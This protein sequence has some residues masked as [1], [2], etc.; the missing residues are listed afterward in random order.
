[1][2]SVLDDWGNPRVVHT[3]QLSEEQHAALP[4]STRE[5]I[6]HQHKTIEAPDKV[7]AA[8]H[9]TPLGDNARTGATR[10][11][12]GHG[13]PVPIAVVG[14]PLTWQRC[15]TAVSVHAVGL[16]PPLSECGEGDQRGPSRMTES[17]RRGVGSSATPKQIRSAPND[18]VPP[19]SVNNGPS[20]GRPNCCGGGCW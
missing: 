3:H 5:Y 19:D 9:P 6:K 11:P 4:R 2:V 16:G 20:S 13:T 8:P 18:E 7:R 14:V 15:P 10:Q 17:E 12:V 1:M